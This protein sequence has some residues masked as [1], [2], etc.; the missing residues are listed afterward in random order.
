MEDKILSESDVRNIRFKKD[1]SLT[2]NAI[3]LQSLFTSRDNDRASL[4]RLA[5][6]LHEATRNLEQMRVKVFNLEEEKKSPHVKLD[7]YA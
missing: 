7:A 2:V 6:S 1:D 3:E 5:D 4:K